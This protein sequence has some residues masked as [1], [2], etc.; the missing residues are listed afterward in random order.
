MRQA[1]AGTI[2]YLSISGEVQPLNG[3][4]GLDPLVQQLMGQRM[5][6]LTLKG[7]EDTM[8]LLSK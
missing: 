8:R 6:P 2:R 3:S 5:Y 1:G 7:L 4:C